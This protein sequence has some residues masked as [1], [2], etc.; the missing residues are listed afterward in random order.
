MSFHSTQPTPT[1]T[2]SE[3]ETFSKEK[4]QNWLKSYVANLLNINSKQVD[5]TVPFDRYGL[6]S[7]STV[8]MLAD[9]EDWLRCTL[10][11]TLVYDYPTIQSLAKHLDRGLNA[12]SHFVDK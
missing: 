1:S 3:R 7:S 12:E 6:D 4:I 9:L 11:P 10:D 8:G 5:I 2:I